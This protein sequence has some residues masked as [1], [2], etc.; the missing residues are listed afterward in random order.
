MVT[1]R[2]FDGVFRWPKSKP[3]QCVEMVIGLA[4]FLLPIYAAPA[5]AD[6]R[7]ATYGNRGYQ[8]AARYQDNFFI[9]VTSNNCRP[10]EQTAFDN[11]RN[12]TAGSDRFSVRWPSGLRMLRDSTDP[13]NGQVTRY[14]DVKIAYSD[15]CNTHGCGTFGGENHSTLAPSSWC[16]YWGA[17][18]PCGS[19]PSEVHINENKWQNTSDAGKVR[20][21]MHE[22]SHS[23]GLAH[24]CSSDSIM[25][26]GSSGCNGGKWTQI[27]SYQPTDRTGIYNIYP[28]WRCP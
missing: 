20:L 18:Q 11:I 26:D 13:C 22:T 12:S 24:H 5:G 21:I 1:A 4:L 23:Q 2:L 9:H 14:V 10:A 3:R 27:M 28:C 25:N 7:Y 19:H 15:F 6:N 8:W 16:N 17:N